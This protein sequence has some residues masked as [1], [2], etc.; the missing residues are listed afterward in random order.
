[1][2]LFSS[3]TFIPHGHCY[4][5]KAGLVWLHIIADASIA[6]AYYSIPIALI[7]FVRKRKDLPFNWI[8][9]LFGAFIIACGTSH[10]MEIWTLWHPTYWLSGFLKAITAVVSLYTALAL[11]P[12][13][14][15]ALALPSPRQLE[16]AN[17]ELEH[18]IIERKLVEDALRESE[19]RFHNAFDY[20]AVGM[21]IVALDGRWVQVNHSLCE[22]VGYCEQEL[23][24]TSFQAITHPDDLECDLYYVNQLL[25][26]KIRY[27]QM[28]KRYFHS[29]GHIVW[30]FLSASLVHDAQGQPLYFV[31]QIQ[32]IT[33][34]KQAEEELRHQKELLQ[35]I[36]DHIPV[37]INFYDVTGET[38]LVNRGVERV[39]GWSKAELQEIDRLAECYPD[40]KEHQRILDFM[41]EA[42]GEWQDFKT[43]TKDG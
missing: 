28:E 8:F 41:R 25:S 24:A 13:V 12:L 39:L 23:L 9:F 26:G 5:W 29:S 27:Y 35:T 11:I 15:K 30:I 4:L 21:A 40:P 18:E 6:I 43:R 10:L 16:K 17:K 37:M 42:S 34:R 7:Y 1:M 36:F 33:Q 19:Q 3:E 38:L 2:H 31:S 22:I 14:P 20:A 32:D